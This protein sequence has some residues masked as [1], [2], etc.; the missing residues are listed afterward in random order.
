MTSQHSLRSQAKLLDVE[1][2]KLYDALKMEFGASVHRNKL[3]W[4]ATHLVLE[5]GVKHV[6]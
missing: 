5:H 4:V 6:G 3:R 1:I 2:K